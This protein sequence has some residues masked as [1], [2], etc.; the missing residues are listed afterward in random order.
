MLPVLHGPWLSAAG[1]LLFGL[2]ARRHVPRPTGEWWIPAV[3]T[4]AATAARLMAGLWGPLH[5][6]GQGPLWIRGATDSAALAGYGPGYFELFSRLAGSGWA[7]DDALFAANALL[8]GSTPALLYVVARLAGVARGGALTAA[9]VLAADAVTVRTAASEGYFSAVIFLVL[10]VQVS[11]ALGVRADRDGDGVAAGCALGGAGLL[12]AAAARIH[13]VAYLPLALCPLVVFGAAQDEGWRTRMARTVAAAAAIGAAVLLTSSAAVLGA[14]TMSGMAGPGLASMMQLDWHVLA[15]VLVAV[16]CAH[17]WAVP[18]WLP[19]V[20][21]CSLVLLLV[22]DDAFAQ[23]PLWALCYQRLF[24]PGVLLGAV[25]LVP[26]RLQGMPWALGAAA[27]AAVA[28]L[29]PALPFLRGQTTEQLEYAFLKQVVA[30]MPATCSVAAVSRAD[31]RVWEIPE[32]LAGEG[33]SASSRGRRSLEDADDLGGAAVSDAC[34]LYVRSSLC[35]SVE[36]RPRCDA[37]ERAARLEQVASRTFPARP[38]YLGLPYD[39]PVVEVTVFRVVTQAVLSGERG[40]GVSDGAA[41]TPAFAQALYE[42]VTPLRPADGCHVTRLDTSR[43]RMSIGVQVPAGTEHGIELATAQSSEAATRQ[44]GVWALAV[45]PDVERECAAMLAAI[46]GVL[47]DLQPPAPV[48]TGSD[49]TGVLDSRV[50]NAAGAV[51]A[52]VAVASRLPARRRR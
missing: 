47:R 24:L 45:P 13:P 38:S 52:V 26:D 5:V 6:N 9:L 2:A 49:G 37:V 19:L 42:R 41:I 40:A 20:G 30:G 32:F 35:S 39:R 7:A 36:G 25:A 22:T 21:A 1:L 31:R 4:L 17:L 14:L 43:F 34:I 10:A 46:E 23:H 28:L 48:N 11:L 44:V 50:G 15:V 12:A 8:A 16:G 18:P 51:L 3:I 27:V 29:L 33:A